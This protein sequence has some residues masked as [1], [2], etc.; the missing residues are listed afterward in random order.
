VFSLVSD[1]DDQNDG[2]PWTLVLGLLGASV[3][4]TFVL[5]VVGAVVETRRFDA[6]KLPGAQTITAVSRD[7]LVAV[8]GRA[9]AAP[10]LA[11]V[12]ALGL[13]YGM[14][15]LDRWKGVVPVVAAL[16]LALSL[17]LV[18]GATGLVTWENAGFVGLIAVGSVLGWWHFGRDQ[19]SNPRHAAVV[20]LGIAG[21]VGIVVLVHIWR[22]PVDL[23]YAQVDLQDDSPVCG[24]YLT[25]TSDALYLAPATMRDGNFYT[26]RRVLVLP[27]T[28]IL[29]I[30]LTRK[31]HVW[32]DGSAGSERSNCPLPSNP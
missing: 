6:L 20:G 32:D 22:P 25:L 10:F 2:I 4:V 14:R 23:E 31:V 26:H 24:V 3:G 8:G 29:R 12:V 11:A 19:R 1:K 7:S 13:F 15:A 18:L 16:L 9:L 21:I 17:A 30:T 28:K 27:R 5:Y